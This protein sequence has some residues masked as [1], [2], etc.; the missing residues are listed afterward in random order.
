M[1][2]IE[3]V[4]PEVINRVPAEFRPLLNL[5]HL[6]TW[7]VDREREHNNDHATYEAT[8]AAFQTALRSQHIK[9][10]GKISAWRRT[11]KVDKHL[12]ALVKSSRDASRALQSLRLSYADH[13]RVVAALPEQRAQKAADKANRRQG[14]GAFVAKSFNKTRDALTPAPAEE[15]TGDESAGQAGA[16]APS[17]IRGVNDLFEKGA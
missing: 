12:K 16:A 8:R 9:G 4:T 13:V 10:D 3:H 1:S 6:T 2:E 5:Q 17:K 15:A 11:R 7:T 14:A